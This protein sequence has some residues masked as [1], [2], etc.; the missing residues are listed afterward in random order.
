MITTIPET[1]P[2]KSFTRDLTGLRFGRLIVVE[3]AG[4]LPYSKNDDSKMAHWKC[5]CDC[6]NDAI[7]KARALLMGGVKSCGCLSKEVHSKALS[8]NKKTK[9]LE[10]G[11]SAK[12]AVYYRYK[13]GA[14][15]RGHSF[16]L[17]L[18]EFLA[19][20]ELPCT[21]CGL[22]P[23]TATN[24]KGLNGQVVY[25]GIDRVNNNL[26]YTKDNSVPCCSKCNFA[27]RSSS[28]EEFKAWVKRV[29]EHL[30]DNHNP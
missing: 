20:C 23:S 9:T 26:G 5:R 8:K 4:Y 7:V 16:E 15:K 22:P 29:Y 19:I 25:S 30:Y 3:F 28:V 24:L 1:T 12:K 14:N 11:L 6:G 27:K 10:Y 21:Y 17:S 2:M 13:A 18:E